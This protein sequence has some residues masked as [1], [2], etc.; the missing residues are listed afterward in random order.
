MSQLFRHRNSIF[1]RRG[2]GREKFFNR[3]GFKIA[4]D[5]FGECHDEDVSAE[6]RQ[7]FCAA[8]RLGIPF[9]G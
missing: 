7:G 1:R 8:G 9:E 5:G 2:R 4:V 3:L 6:T